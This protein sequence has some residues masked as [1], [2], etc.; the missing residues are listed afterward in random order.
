M[1]PL[2]NIESL[3]VDFI[4]EEGTANA[5]TDVSFT[6]DRGESVAIVGESGCGKSAAALSIP[7]L[8]PSPPGIIKS[9]RIFFKGRDLAAM[10]IA[11][12]RKVRG[13]QI[14][15]V[16]QD[17]MT[18]LSPLHTIEYQMVETLRIHSREPLR[19]LRS[20]AADFLSRSG[21]PAGK[22]RSLPFKLSG[23]QQQRVMITSAIMTS[24]DLIIADEPTTAL[25]ASV[26]SQIL[27]L[28][29]E[30]KGEN[31]ALLL[32]THN[33]ALVRGICS[34]VYV[35]YAGEIVETGPVSDVFNSP[36]HPYTAALM[37]AMPSGGKRGQ[38]LRAIPGSVPPPTALPAGCRFAPRCRFAVAECSLRHSALAPAGG[39]Q[40]HFSRCPVVAGSALRHEIQ[41]SGENR[42]AG[43]GTED[44]HA[45]A[46]LLET[47]EISK[48][49]GR[50]KAVDSVSIS[51][52]H[53]ETL[54]VVG[55]SGCGK[56]TLAR[57]IAGLEK[58][59]SGSLIF[60]GSPIPE[61]RTQDMRRRI[62]MIFQ[63]PFSSL[64][65]RM[66]A[67]GIVTEGAVANGLIKRRDAPGFAVKL[68]QSVGMSEDCAWR[69]PH[70]F[71]GGQRQRISIARAIS[72]N[73]EIIVCDEPV[74]ALDVSVQAQV[75]NLLASLQEKL[76][77]SYIFITHD[78]S[79]VRRIAHRIAVMFSG[80]IVEYGD[81]GRVLNAPSHEY[82]RRLLA[83]EPRLA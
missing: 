17:P 48:S 7:R 5:V 71:S 19:E 33:M 12:L 30:S 28:M 36:A 32:I 57:I 14:G 2:L 27:K 41:A 75:L 73:P 51:V 72:M 24:P 61:K 59:D 67:A 40:L 43:T 22:L 37:D 18:A 23:G 82:T 62:Q 46:P 68:L 1:T 39:S 56:T 29:L 55:E 45:A 15:V 52:G 13:A 63:N 77:I 31:T 4:T 34:R 26:Q 50:L 78:I 58:P 81:A 65:P 11:E 25:D 10:P 42:L 69:Y 16:F 79:V 38:P 66:T 54:A 76:G 83:A 35:M 21:V 20:K 49:F 3:S 6:V 8:I 9:G 44:T 60:G 70:E 74:S 53:G 64:N 47:R 80:R